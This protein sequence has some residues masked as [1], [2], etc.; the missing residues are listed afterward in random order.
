MR[1]Q[2]TSACATVAEGS[3]AKERE[4]GGCYVLMRGQCELG[5]DQAQ[6][7]LLQLLGQLREQVQERMGAAIEACGA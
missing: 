7:L 2:H 3:A 6:L 4:A 5:P 1:S